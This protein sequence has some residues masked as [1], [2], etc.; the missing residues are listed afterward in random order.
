MQTIDRP[1]AGRDYRLFAL[2]YQ[3]GQESGE[4]SQSEAYAYLAMA[5][6]P[7]DGSAVDAYCQGSADGAIGDTYRLNLC[8]GQLS[9]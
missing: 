1:I 9:F 6:K 5:Y 2:G 3:R 8:T 7:C 4:V